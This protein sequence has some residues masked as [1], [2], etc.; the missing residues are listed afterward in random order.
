MPPSTGCR[1]VGGVAGAVSCVGL[2]RGLA[3]F[4]TQAA[5]PGGVTGGVRGRC[6]RF[7][8][9]WRGAGGRVLG[10]VRGVVR[11]VCG[12]PTAVFVVTCK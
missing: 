8:L 3:R 9:S 6:C 11:V 4:A 7:L 1:V 10:A 5:G 2:L 12:V